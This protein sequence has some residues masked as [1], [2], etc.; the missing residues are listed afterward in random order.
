[1]YKIPG[2]SI[3][4]RT[5]LEWVKEMLWVYVAMKVFRAD[6]EAITGKPENPPKE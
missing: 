3:V 4:C 1:M 2:R 6:I 5:P